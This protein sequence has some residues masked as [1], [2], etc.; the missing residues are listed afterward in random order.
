[1]ANLASPYSTY[2]DSTP[3]KRIVEDYI[4]MLDP[5]DAPLID[6]IGGLDG[7]SSKFQFTGKGK[8]V[9]WL[10]DT[11]APLTG[12]MSVT[13]NGS[14]VA[15]T[16]VTA[17]TVA[18]GN[19]IQP[20]HILLV[21]AELMW[22][23]AVTPSSGAI[24]VIRAIGGT[25]VAS[26]ASNATFSVVGMARLEG[27]DSD[28]IGYTDISSNSN[29]TQIFHKELKITGS[30][31]A[32]DNYGFS[33][34]Y[35]YQAAK[36]IPEM[37][38][39]IE[40]A[41]FY[42]KAG[43]AGSATAPRYMGGLQAFIST[44]NYASGATLSVA[45]I[46]D[47]VELAYNAGGGGDY[48]A[49]VAP[50]TYQVVKNLYDSSAFV[51]YA[52]EQST[53]GTLVDKIITPFGN[54]TFVIDRWCPSTLIPILKTEN[55]GMVTLRPWQVEDLAKS[56]DYQKTQLLGEFTLAMRLAKSHA[57]LTAVSAS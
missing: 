16:S 19:M 45:K 5:S 42:Q 22:V 57:L 28:S 37:M 4:A 35:Q 26:F 39:L 30:E 7:G 44:D 10:E 11:L 24:T 51:R 49:V 46:E 21:G 18:D 56:G 27:D 15:T 3:Q 13:G 29:Y 38:R 2:S 36:S 23:E 41:L 43:S 9:E 8:V 55:V 34:P 6:L 48:V 12:A 54:V 33:D 52:P 53:F 14:T 40:R 31:M 32:I 25:S 17:L 20:G 50:S 47:A 1:M